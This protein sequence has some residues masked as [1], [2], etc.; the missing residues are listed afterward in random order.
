MMTR[1]W[2]NTEKLTPDPLL[3]SAIKVWEKWMPSNYTDGNGRTSPKSIYLSACTE[4]T[5][6]YLIEQSGGKHGRTDYQNRIFR[7]NAEVLY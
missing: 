3:C 1:R 5:A 4:R 2:K 7:G 6:G